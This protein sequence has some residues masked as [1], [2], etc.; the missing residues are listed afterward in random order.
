MVY[1][2]EGDEEGGGGE[3]IGELIGEEGNGLAAMFHMMNEAR[4]SVGLG[5]AALGYCGYVKSLEYARERKQGRTPGV[6][7]QGMKPSSPQVPII[8]HADVK[9]MLLVQKSYVEGALSLGL[10]GCSLVDMINVIQDGIHD[11]GGS[12]NVAAAKEKCDDMKILLDTL[13]PI[14]KVQNY[15]V[16]C[17]FL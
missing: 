6:D 16:Y 1:G 14:I 10:Y 2:G 8:Q 11:M 15:S 13:T 9:R 4:I 17:I 12:N 7:R 5:A 3:C